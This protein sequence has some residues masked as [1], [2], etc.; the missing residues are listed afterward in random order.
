MNDL[1]A[2]MNGVRAKALPHE[3]L[4]KITMT[5][6]TTTVHRVLETTPGIVRSLLSAASDDL[7]DFRDGP[8]AW[9]ARQVLTH[10]A[11]GEITDWMPRIELILSDAAERRF[12]PFN[13][14]GGFARYDG[15][16]VP[17]LL[18]E[19]ERLRT[20]NLARLDTRDLT[21]DDLARTGIHPELGQVTLRQLIACWATHDLAHLN[22]LSRLF[23]R[24]IGPEVGP[25]K[26][27]FSLLKP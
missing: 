11:E 10:L 24:G 16:R 2:V 8:D 12:V 13:R 7:L 18:D 22:Q 3:A 15:W 1:Q 20:A 14:E 25:W 17:A 19:F 9:D 26:V 4:A 21:D 5:N 27:F 6:I 23:V